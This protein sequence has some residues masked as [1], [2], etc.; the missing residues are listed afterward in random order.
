MSVRSV[1]RS[2]APLRKL[3]G[4]LSSFTKDPKDKPVSSGI[5]SSL[6][7]LA[8]PLV[9]VADQVT[10][11]DASPLSSSYVKEFCKLQLPKKLLELLGTAL[12]AL[13][14]PKETPG[15]GAILETAG[16][17]W[18]VAAS[19][20]TDVLWSANSTG[21]TAGQQLL[22]AQLLPQRLE[23]DTSGVLLA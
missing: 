18:Y 22:L 21:D 8:G 3:V 15:F 9:L 13:S 12:Q 17:V 6:E 5:A 23:T 7:R 16:G 20:L 11:Y 2:L 1:P 10:N 4:A 14:T 19:I